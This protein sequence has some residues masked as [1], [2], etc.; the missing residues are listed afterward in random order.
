MSRTMVFHAAPDPHE[1]EFDRSLRPGSFE[2]F[3][4][5]EQI[6]DNLRIAW[7]YIRLA[8]AT[9]WPAR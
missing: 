8:P 1:Q 9:W 4:G 5:Q 3:V 6:R 7:A 2:D